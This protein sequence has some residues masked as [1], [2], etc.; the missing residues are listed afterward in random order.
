VITVL[1]RAIRLSMIALHL[2]FGAIT[3]VAVVWPLGWRGGAHAWRAQAG[4][5][6][7]WSR[8]LCRILGLRI[9]LGGEPLQRP[10]L[11]VCNHISWLD[12]IGLLAIS[13]ALF[14]SKADVRRWPLIGWLAAQAGTLFIARGAFGAAN[15]AITDIS[16]ILAADR[17]V[18]IFPEGTST[19]GERVAHFHPRLFEAAISAAVPVQ[20]IAIRYTDANGRRSAVAPFIGDDDFVAHLTRVTGAPRVDVSYTVCPAVNSAGQDRR[21]LA[22]ITRDQ[23]ALV[24]DG[25]CDAGLPSAPDSAAGHSRATGA[26]NDSLQRVVINEEM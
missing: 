4:I 5:V 1:R 2:V 21:A 17:S 6:S 13:D 7:L 25:F 19:D 18:V 26:G 9:R 20:A 14:L 11:L 16:A 8:M 22:D 15:K 3:T 23:I 10:V 12:I 24:L